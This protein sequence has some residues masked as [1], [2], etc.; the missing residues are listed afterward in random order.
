M[1]GLPGS[2]AEADT[3]RTL[4]ADDERTSA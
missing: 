1:A 3:K 4:W 2:F